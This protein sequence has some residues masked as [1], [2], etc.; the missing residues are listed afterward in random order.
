M[1]PKS[2]NKQSSLIVCMVS[3][4][5][6][7]GPAEESF[8]GWTYTISAILNPIK[9]SPD[10]VLIILAFLKPSEFCGST[11]RKQA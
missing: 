10:S 4:T 1:K 9:V 6:G 11:F 2:K 8:F 7:K 5:K 3:T